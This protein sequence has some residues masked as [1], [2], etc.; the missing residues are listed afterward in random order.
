MELIKVKSSLKEYHV[1]SE[2][3][4]GAYAKVYKARCLRTSRS[5]AIKV[6]N[7]SEHSPSSLKYILNEA[8]FLTKVKHTNII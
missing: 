3:A 2:L 5:V 6:I 1:E 8:L 7:T 4:Q